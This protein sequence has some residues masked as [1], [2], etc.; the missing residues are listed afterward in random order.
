MAKVNKKTSMKPEEV[1]HIAVGI[2]KDR[3][4]GSIAAVIL[5]LLIVAKMMEQCGYRHFCCQP[6]VLITS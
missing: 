2:I 1:K 3:A 5:M 6:R 4:A